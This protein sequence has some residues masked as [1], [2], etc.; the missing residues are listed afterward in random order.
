MTASAMMVESTARTLTGNLSHFDR[1][2]KCWIITPE[3]RGG[4]LRVLKESCLTQCG[5]ADAAKGDSII[6]E[7]AHER[8]SEVSRVVSILKQKRS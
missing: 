8:S 5:F 1:A 2:K 4:P 7:I 3:D 6:F